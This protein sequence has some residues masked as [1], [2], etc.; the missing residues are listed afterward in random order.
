MINNPEMSISYLRDLFIEKYMD[1]Q[2]DV[3]DEVPEV[4]VTMTREQYSE[5][6]KDINNSAMN[7]LPIVDN[8]LTKLPNEGEILFT[9]LSIPFMCEFIIQIGDEFDFRLLDEQPY[10][11]EDL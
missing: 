8:A 9:R 7:V 5:L 4:V 3:G 10:G 1:G 2:I 6:Y 11:D